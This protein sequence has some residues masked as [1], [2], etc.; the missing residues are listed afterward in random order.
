MKHSLIKSALLALCLAAANSHAASTAI[1]FTDN[2][3]GGGTRSAAGSY[4]AST[5]AIDVT[6][7]SSACVGRP[8]HPAGERPAP[9]PNDGAHDGP[10]P[11][12]RNDSQGIPTANGT[13]SIKGIFLENSGVYTLDLVET[14]NVTLSFTGGS[15][16]Q[17]SCTVTRKGS[18]DSKTNLFT[19]SVVR[20]NCSSSGTYPE[21][22]GMVEHLLLRAASGR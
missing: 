8:P 12:A 17:R 3:E 13:E 19:G 18:L 6:I 1:S 10:L 16:T 5:G 9:P 7:T 14:A 2:C 11:P 4:D 15:S 22:V 20:S 21:R